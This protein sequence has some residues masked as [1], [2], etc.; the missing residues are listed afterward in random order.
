[1]VKQTWP[2]A[3]IRFRGRYWG[4]ADMQFAPRMS[5]FD[6]KWTSRYS[7]RN[8]SFHQKHG[9]VSC[10]AWITLVRAFAF[11]FS[12][13]WSAH[14]LKALTIA[15]FGTNDF[16]QAEGI[17]LVPKSGGPLMSFN[18]FVKTRRATL[19][20]NS[21]QKTLPRLPFTPLHCW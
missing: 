6:A 10:M 9:H 1:G 18:P 20:T 21:K 12:R 8:A 15:S 2:F 3:E 17:D 14:S 13:C 19:E 5:A 7:Q 11:Q 4:K 16:G